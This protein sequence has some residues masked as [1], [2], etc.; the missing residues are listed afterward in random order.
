M[1]Q[2]PPPEPTLE[3]LKPV[4]GAE[5]PLRRNISWKGE[6]ALVLL[7]T[8]VILA[9]LGL[10]EA[11]THQRL[12]FASLASSAFLIYLDPQHGTNT[13]RTLVFSQFLAATVGFLT[14]TILGAEYLSVGTAVVATIGLMLL[15][16]AVHPPAVAT[17]LSFAWRAGD[18]R[19]L[20]L[21]ALAL[22]IT[23]TLVVLQRAA[24]W[25]LAHYARKEK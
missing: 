24:V 17:G 21:F 18:E 19:N 12:L 2:T 3:S 22:G 5:R 23:A 4:R 9:V 8:A 6:L 1:E 16:D 10:V 14:H 11:L 25:T 7:P 13:V 20:V 15:F